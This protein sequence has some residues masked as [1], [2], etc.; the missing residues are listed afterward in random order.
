MVK[1]GINLMIKLRIK[2]RIRTE[3]KIKLRIKFRIKFWIRVRIELRIISRITLSITTLRIKLNPPP[4]QT[5]NDT[6]F[7]L[8]VSKIYFPYIRPS[9][10]I[11]RQL[12]INF[13]E[14]WSFLNPLHNNVSNISLTRII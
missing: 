12:K 11:S 7:C 13:E 4:T 9:F 14:S 1:F 5:F 2:V 6:Y 3:L 8:C 10:Q